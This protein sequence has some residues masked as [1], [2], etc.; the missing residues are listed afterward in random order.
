MKRKLIIIHMNMNGWLIKH[1]FF[2]DREEGGGVLTNKVI[3][4]GLERASS[5]PFTFPLSFHHK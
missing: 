4:S 2:N 5:Y 1:G 3:N